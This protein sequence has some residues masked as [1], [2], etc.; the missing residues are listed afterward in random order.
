MSVQKTEGRKQ[1]TEARLTAETKRRRGN[2][3]GA[4]LCGRPGPRRRVA[5]TSTFVSLTALLLIATIFISACRWGGNGITDP[6]VGDNTVYMA[7]N[8]SL[9]SG[10]T[11]AVDV[12]VEGVNNVYGAA[13]DVDFDSTKMTYTGCTQGSFL[14]QSGGCMANPQPGTSGKL[15]VGISRQGTANGVSGSGTLVT[16]MFRPTESSSVTFSNAS[17]KDSSNQP[18]SGITWTD[19]TVTVQ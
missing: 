5:P 9:S 3:V 12:K 16:L 8:S 10:D 6:S 18:I 14:E 1:N 19:G 4:L 11:V 15:V 13:F 7:R 17:L 2:D